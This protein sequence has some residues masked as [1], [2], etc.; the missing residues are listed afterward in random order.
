MMTSTPLHKDVVANPAMEKR[1]KKAAPS[2]G[3]SCDG[4]ISI[5]TAVCKCGGMWLLFY[6]LLALQYTRTTIRDP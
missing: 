3:E 5:S 1:Q 2:S 4:L 6:F